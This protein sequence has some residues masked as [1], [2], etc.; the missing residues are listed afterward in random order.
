MTDRDTREGDSQANFINDLVSAFT[1]VTEKPEDRYVVVFVRLQGA[2][3]S[4]VFMTH[5][6]KTN[7][8]HFPGGKVESEETLHATAQRELQE[9]TGLV[10]PDAWLYEVWNSKPLTLKGLPHGARRLSPMCLSLLWLVATARKTK[11]GR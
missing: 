9:E 6:A 4:M 7:T 8:I 5:E 3:N 2:T 11:Q 1:K 10:I